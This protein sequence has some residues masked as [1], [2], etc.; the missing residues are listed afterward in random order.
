MIDYRFPVDY[1]L[2][3]GSR[4]VVER[5]AVNFK[6]IADSV[7]WLD[8]VNDWIAQRCV[9]FCFMRKGEKTI[10]KLTYFCRWID[11][12]KKKQV[13]EQIYLFLNKFRGYFFFY[14]LSWCS[15]P[16]SRSRKFLQLTPHNGRYPTSRGLNIFSFYFIF[17]Y[18]W[19]LFKYVFFFTSWCTFFGDVDDVTRKPSITQP[20][21]LH[22]G[23]RQET[24]EEEERRNKKKKIKKIVTWHEFSI[25]CLNFKKKKVAHQHGGW[26]VSLHR[27]TQPVTIIFKNI[28]KF[29]FY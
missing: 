22:F 2:K 25:F 13:K 16:G 28:Y 26:Q 4:S 8:V 7:T 9:F 1:P 18:I 14:L 29:K 23:I 19:F 5:C 21:H 27:T 20:V 17:F 3:T 6:L 24:N 12:K 10:T 15:S 11:W